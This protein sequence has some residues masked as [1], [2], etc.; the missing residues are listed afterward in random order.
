MAFDAFS[1]WADDWLGFVAAALRGSALLFALA[2][3]VWL[4]LRRRLPAQ[5]VYVLFLLVLLRLAMPWDVELP[6]W[7]AA[8]SP[9]YLV[10]NAWQYWTAPPTPPAP[11]VVLPTVVHEAAAANEIAPGVPWQAWVFGV[12]ASVVGWLVLR[13]A[14]R[15]LRTQALVRRARELG[16]HEL[17]PCPVQLRK[18]AGLRRRVRFLATHEVEVPAAGGL[19]R[20]YVLLPEGLMDEL[21]VEQ[22]RFVLLHELA[23]IRRGDLWVSLFQRLVGMAFFFHPLV[24]WANRIIDEQREFACDDAALAACGGRKVCGQGF[25]SVVEWS[26]GRACAPAG[27]LGMFHS[28]NVIRRRLMRILDGKRKVGGRRSATVC[29]VLVLAL[30]VVAVPAV[31][32]QDPKSERELEM[33]ILQA[34][35][36]KLEAESRIVRLE[37]Q[38]LQ[39]KKRAPKAAKREVFWDTRIG[40]SPAE[41]TPSGSFTFRDAQPTPVRVGDEYLRA[42]DDYVVVYRKAEEGESPTRLDLS[43]ENV[44]FGRWDEQT[45]EVVESPPDE[46]SRPKADPKPVRYDRARGTVIYDVDENEV[47]GGKAVIDLSLQPESGARYLYVPTLELPKGGEGGARVRVE[48]GAE[49]IELPPGAEGRL[50]RIVP[51]AKAGECTRLPTLVETPVRADVHVRTVERSAGDGSGSGDA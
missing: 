47:K 25:L 30:G 12:W 49:A 5:V 16:P 27:A 15:Q 41:T 22:R 1:G 17:L 3:V 8:F 18:Q 4:P 31:K 35:L 45:G 32:A 9:Q 13:F 38:K 19:L 2:L 50:I 20:S 7:L 42:G 14:V 48:P 21:T 11:A 29:T 33:A 28:D 24:W 46:E 40:S 23:H 39:Q 6:G 36:D 43:L 10:E 51:G 44:T 26:Q 37:L 34:K